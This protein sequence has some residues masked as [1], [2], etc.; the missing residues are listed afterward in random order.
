MG[1]NSQF[2]ELKLRA[3]LCPSLESEWGAPESFDHWAALHRAA[4]DLRASVAYC[5]AGLAKIEQSKDLTPPAKKRARADLAYQALAKLEQLPSMDK[6]RE[7]VA[8]NTMKLQ[9]KIDAVLTRPKPDDA[10]SALLLREVR[11]RFAAIK[12]EARLQWLERF[13]IEPIVPSALLHGPV[14]LTGLSEPERALLVSKVEALAEIVAAKAA[15][16]RALAE[17]DRAARA[18]PQLIADCAGIRLGA[19]PSTEPPEV[20]PL[21]KRIDRDPDLGRLPPRGVHAP[22][23]TEPPEPPKAAPNWPGSGS[24]T[25]TAVDKVPNWT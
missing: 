24:S 15:L 8:A 9:A 6:A 25:P 12:P 16:N 3:S 4:T 5:F 18:A 20:K 14:G 19:R 13:G 23:L 10:A 21:G 2:A 17:L 22:D 11:D 7:S 1:V